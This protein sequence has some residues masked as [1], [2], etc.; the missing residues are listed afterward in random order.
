[1]VT[2]DINF[3]TLQISTFKIFILHLKICP[4]EYECHKDLIPIIFIQKR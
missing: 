3:G 4:V 1:M 2:Y